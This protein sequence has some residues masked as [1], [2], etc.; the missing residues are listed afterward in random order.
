MGRPSIAALLFFAVALVYPWPARSAEV[1]VGLVQLRTEDA[2]NFMVMKELAK[3][4]RD[5]GATLVIFPEASDLG[6]LNPAAFTQAEPIPGRYSDAFAD[7]ASE[8]GLWVAA[9]LTEKGPKAGPGSRPDAFLAYDSGIL[10]NPKGQVVLHHRQFNVVKNAFDSVACQ[11][12][13]NEPQCSYTPG[14]KEDIDIVQT[15]LGRTALLVCADAYTYAPAAALERLK[16][17][18]PDFVIVPWGI[19]ASV[20]NQCGTKDFNAT[21]YAAEAATFL[22][23]AFVVGANAVGERTYGRFLPSVYCGD[24]GYATPTGVPVEAA[25]PRSALVLVRIPGTFDAPAG[26]LKNETDATR[27]CPGVCNSYSSAWNR[28]WEAANGGD[29]GSCGCMVDAGP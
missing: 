22:K 6:W 18:S 14:E 28:D 1:I 24:S 4:A 15:P 21:R 12:I 3:E 7:I 25:L 9:G 29:A 27:I 19:T 23:S 2:G 16:T 20:Q 26:P 13:F 17:L 11:T 5:Q 10:I 8:L